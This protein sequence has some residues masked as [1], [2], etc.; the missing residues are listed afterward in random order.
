MDSF[1]SSGIYLAIEKMRHLTLR[2]LFR[3]VA[4]QISQS[5]EQYLPKE[6]LDRPHIM[7]LKI[8]FEHLLKWDADLDMDELECILANLI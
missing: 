6:Y 8:P 5:P 3:S 4:V 7:P 2:N 1:V